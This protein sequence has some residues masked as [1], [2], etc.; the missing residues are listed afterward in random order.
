MKVYYRNIY[1]NKQEAIV[2]FKQYGQGYQINNFLLSKGNKIL[3]F[4]RIY[5]MHFEGFLEEKGKVL[6]FAISNQKF[7]HVKFD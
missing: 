5:L 4:I 3:F 1:I 2:I 7:L 6:G